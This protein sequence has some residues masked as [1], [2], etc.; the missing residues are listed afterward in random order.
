MSHAG[1][2]IAVLAGFVLSSLPALAQGTALPANLPAK[3][4]V[5]NR[6]IDVAPDG[7]ATAATHSETKILL[8]NAIAQLGQL[9]LTFSDQLQ[10][11]DVNSA[12][13]LKSDGRKIPV[14]PDAIIV[15][16]SPASQ[17]A[18]MLSDLKQKVI[19]FPEV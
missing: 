2:R 19:I 17:N 3:I 5:L 14:G 16:Q 15:Q 7:G 4:T 1:F 6:Q 9:K 11:V 12:Y 13:T 8:Q 10:Q 18:P